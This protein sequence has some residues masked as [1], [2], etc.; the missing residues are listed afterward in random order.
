MPLQID[1]ENVAA[2]SIFQMDTPASKPKRA[3]GRKSSLASRYQ[4]L[5]KTELHSLDA[6]DEPASYCA[7]TSNSERPLSR[8]SFTSGRTAPISALRMD[9]GD[10]GGKEVLGA[11]RVGPGASRLDILSANSATPFSY[12]PKGQEKAGRAGKSRS[13]TPTLPRLPG[14]G[15]SRPGASWSIPSYVY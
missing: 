7:S 4:A 6:C 14:L 13:S 5:G 10:A 8:N 15:V 12:G 11:S 2:V 1:T 9:L 3:S